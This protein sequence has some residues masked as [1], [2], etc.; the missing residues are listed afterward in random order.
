MSFLQ[1]DKLSSTMITI[2]IFISHLFFLDA[3]MLIFTQN[4][5]N[6]IPL[7]PQDFQKIIRRNFSFLLNGIIVKFVFRLFCFLFNIDR[8]RVILP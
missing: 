6:F 1:I 3:F 4:D 7:F 2:S 8:L 5:V